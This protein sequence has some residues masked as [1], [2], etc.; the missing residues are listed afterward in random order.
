VE[1]KPQVA[2]TRTSAS[3]P[4][5]CILRFRSLTRLA[6]KRLE[7]EGFRVEFRRGLDGAVD[8]SIFDQP[9]GTFVVRRAYA[10]I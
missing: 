4:P 9:N 6:W 3:E 10:A 2:P 5:P 1:V 8:D 7:L